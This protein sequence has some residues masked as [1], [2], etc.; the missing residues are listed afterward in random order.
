VAAVIVLDASVLI[1][2]LDAGD[3]HHEA[4]AE[5]LEQAIDDDL[6][7]STVTLAEVLVGPVRS[8]RL[9]AALA[10]LTDL[11]VAEIRLPSEAALE[12]ARL[13]GSTNLRLPDCSVLLAARQT[14]ARVAS[15]D[16]PLLAAATA[17]GLPT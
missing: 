17:L 3:A 9:D 10:A 11:E 5:L 1:A 8:G 15:F 4:A 14:G 13:R 16:R 2:H 12:L 7:A 6:A